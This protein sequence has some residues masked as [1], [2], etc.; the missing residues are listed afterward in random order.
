MLFRSTQTE[1]MA[2]FEQAERYLQGYGVVTKPLIVQPDNGTH[3]LLHAHDTL[4][5]DL[6]AVGSR[7]KNTLSHLLLGSTSQAILEQANCSVLIVH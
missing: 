2:L 7:G 3:A 6:I 4:S 1:G 5:P